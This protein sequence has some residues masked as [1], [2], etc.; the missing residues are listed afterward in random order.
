M[1]LF[2]HLFMSRLIAIIAC[3]F[4][5]IYFT[6]VLSLDS[7]LTNT[8]DAKPVIEFLTL[9]LPFAVLLPIVSFVNP[10]LVQPLH[11]A[12]KYQTPL[13]K[14]KVLSYRHPLR[15]SFMRN[16]IYCGWF[17]V[18]RIIRIERRILLYVKAG[19]IWESDKY[20]ANPLFVYYLIRFKGYE[21]S[22][23]E[24]FLYKSL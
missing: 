16:K 6:M 3:V 1:Y 7:L 19:G 12:L 8:D 22:S 24:E 10:F 23:N 14:M 20:R 11:Q 17:G 5:Y 4:G 21:V 13:W 15:K 2:N 9:C 18:I